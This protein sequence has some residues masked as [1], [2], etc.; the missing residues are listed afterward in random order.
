[1]RAWSVLAPQP[2]VRGIARV[3]PARWLWPTSLPGGAARRWAEFGDTLDVLALQE[4][5]FHFERAN[6]RGAGVEEPF[7]EA[8][9]AAGFAGVF[10]KDPLVSRSPYSGCALYWRARTFAAHGAISDERAMCTVLPCGA[11]ALG[12]AAINVDLDEHW[13]SNA[14]DGARV[15]MA[16][17]D[18]RNAG[19]VKLVHRGSGELLCMCVTH[20]MTTSRDA[21]RTNRFPGEVRAGE[22]ARIRK[23]FAEVL[24]KQASAV[25]L[26]DFNTSAG[27][28]QIFEGSL[29][30][31]DGAAYKV[32]TGFENCTLAWRDSVGLPIV[33]QVAETHTRPLHGISLTSSCGRELSEAYSACVRTTKRAGGLRK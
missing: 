2:L 32:A 19:L 5:D 13:H 31:D 9:A 17:A 7:H 29:R 4:Y 28:R 15:R 27:D 23:L 26:G 21:K 33:L 25:I 12:G 1:M 18:R 11:T 10:F 14:A 3:A 16:D 8:M 20:L 24:P 22:I 6:Y 30:A